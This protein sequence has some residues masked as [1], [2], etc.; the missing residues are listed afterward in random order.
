VLDTGCG[1]TSA[2]TPIHGLDHRGVHHQ[3][4]RALRVDA[5]A[6]HGNEPVRVAACLVQVV[7]HEHDRA[8]V[9]LV[10]LGEEVE[11]LELVGEVEVGGRL[12]EQEYLGVLGER[13]RDPGAL[14]LPAGEL[15][16][17]PVPE[18]A[19]VRRLQRPVDLLLVLGR[20]LLEEALMRVAPARHEVLDRE[21]LRRLRRLRQQADPPRHLARRE[22]GDGLAVEQ[23]RAAARSHE[24][25]QPTQES[26]LAAGVGADYC[27][28]TAGGDLEVELANHRHIRVREREA[29][30]AQAARH[31]ITLVRFAR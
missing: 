3:L 12:V 21:P 15:V 5:A 11:H 22:P 17:G 16:E 14:A 13:H 31:S 1:T 27:R 8:P 24:T 20:P 6:R 9:P 30:R 10:Q 23:H 29:V 25:S 28:D 26:G 4:R 2:S 18:G 19:D 7:E